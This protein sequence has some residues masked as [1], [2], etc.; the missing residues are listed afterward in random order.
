MDKLTKD[1]SAM[2]TVKAAIADRRGVMA[3]LWA[4]VALTVGLLAA[5]CSCGSDEPEIIFHSYSGEYR[6]G[7]K[8]A[9]DVTLNSVKLTD[10]NSSVVVTTSDN[11]IADITIKN[12]IPGYGEVPVGGVEIVGLAGGK[13]VGFEGKVPLS[14]T[15]MAVFKGTIIGGKMTLD[16]STVAIPAH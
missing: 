2:T 9:L 4:M 1:N 16:I 12:I 6:I 15:E 10:K 14:T 5:M 13:G 7:E 8:M 11:K 3:R